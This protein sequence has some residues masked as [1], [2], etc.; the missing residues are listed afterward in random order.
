MSIA[1]NYTTMDVKVKFLGAA[2]TVTGSRF[3][4]EIGSFRVLV[5]CG[6]FQGLKENR[7]RNWDTF[8]IRPETI[9]IV[10]LTHAHIDHS[11]YLPKLVKE[12][13]QGPI[14]LTKASLALV[15]ILLLDAGKLQEEEAKFARKKG[16]SKHSNP[17]PLFTREDADKVFPRLKP[18]SFDQAVKINDQLSITAYNA[19]H[20]LGAAILKLQVSGDKQEKSIVFSGD[21]GRTKDPILNPPA[22][23]PFADVLFLETTYGNRVNESTGIDRKLGKVIR[24]TYYDGGVSLIP[25]F[26]VGRTQMILFYLHR[27]QQKGFIPQIPIYVDSPMAIDVTSL[28]KDFPEYHHL[29]P[30]L[31]NSNSNP[32]LHKNLHY[33]RDQESSISLNNIKNNA[34]IIS[35]SGMATGGRIL[36]HLYNRLPNKEDSILFV[37][38]QAE[39]TRGRRILEGEETCR[40]YGIDV[41]VKAKPYYIDGL[42]AHADQTELVDWCD[43][44]ISKPKFTFLIH[45][46]PEAREELAGILKDQLNWNTISPLYMESFLLF[47]G[48]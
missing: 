22:E 44:F 13:Y 37:G 1:P 19:G 4:L 8:P 10:L 31:E 30:S 11:G 41:P 42:S 16:Y 20:I 2:G 47:S 15:K 18:I 3:F 26:A 43:N 7:L 12:G 36:H 27:L 38:Y 25:S 32:F 29:G 35:A 34:I 24:D 23:I 9:D 48:I 45:G 6:L 46:E 40:I 17:Q 39:G 5:D 33:Y 28:Y 21:L 14:Y